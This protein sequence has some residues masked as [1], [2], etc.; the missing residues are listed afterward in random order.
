MAHVTRGGVSAMDVFERL[1]FHVRKPDG[2]LPFCRSQRDLVPL[3]NSGTRLAKEVQNITS[4]GFAG[5]LAASTKKRNQHLTTVIERADKTGIMSYDEFSRLAPRRLRVRCTDG[6]DVVLL[7]AVNLYHWVSLMERN[8]A[9]LLGIK[10]VDDLENPAIVSTTAMYPGLSGFTPPSTSCRSWRGFAYFRRC[11]PG[12]LRVSVV[13][14]FMLHFL[15]LVRNVAGRMALGFPKSVEIVDLVNSGVSGLSDALG[16][17]DPWR[18]NKFTTFATPRIRGAILDELRELDWVP[19]SVR[20]KER[21]FESAILSLQNEFGRIPT[22]GEIAQRLGATYEQVCCQLED[23]HATTLLS[24]DELVYREEDNR[25]VPR[26]ETLCDDDFVSVLD[27]L[28]ADDILA[29]VKWGIYRLLTPQQAAVFELY[30]V[31]GLTMRQ[32]GERLKVSESRASQVHTAGI[33]QLR[34]ACWRRFGVPRITEAD[35]G[36]LTFHPTQLPMKFMIT[37]RGDG[38]NGANIQIPQDVVWRCR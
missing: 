3:T 25:Q 27:H 21:E 16:R 12:S 11:P 14:K 18:G 2:I 17:Y 6:Q 7:D 24:L 30:Y 15:P 34:I 19:R 13:Q 22:Y 1:R 29:F 10:G 32:V 33:R 37:H 36:S 35:D 4:G 31:H 5:A 20:S 38:D 28:I 8:S 9:F 23:I 26:V